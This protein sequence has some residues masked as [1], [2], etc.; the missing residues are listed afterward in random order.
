MT[1]KERTS[2]NMTSRNQSPSYFTHSDV[3]LC[4]YLS[5]CSKCFPGVSNV[6][7]YLSLH[8]TAIYWLH[9]CLR[10]TNA[11]MTRAACI[12]TCNMCISQ[13]RVLLSTGIY[14]I[15]PILF[16]DIDPMNSIMPLNKGKNTASYLTEMN[17][18]NQKMNQLFQNFIHFPH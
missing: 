4:C 2:R 1:Y 14:N 18:T 15:D 13:H 11:C 5:I 17:L 6:H 16:V 7:M 8:I 3:G 12:N 9:L 10:C